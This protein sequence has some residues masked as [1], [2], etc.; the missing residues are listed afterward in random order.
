MPV[1][2]HRLRPTRHDAICHALRLALELPLDLRQET[3]DDLAEALGRFLPPETWSFVMLNPDQQRYVLKAIHASARPFN[4]LL[5]WN[6]CISRLHYDTGEIMASRTQLA[7]DAQTTVQEVSRAL[8]KLAEIGALV[9]LERARYA[10][11]PYVGWMGSLAKR[12]EAA[13][14]QPGIC[15]TEPS[16]RN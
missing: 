7:E 12:Q 6:A 4:T 10:I 1:K 9:K 15:L 16:E 13:K 3:L 14:R 11:N 5:V 8:S 2:I